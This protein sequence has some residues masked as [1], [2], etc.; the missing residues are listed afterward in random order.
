MYHPQSGQCVQLTKNDIVLANCKTASRW[1]QHQDG[2]PIK[3]A[4]SPQCLAVAGDGAAARASNDCSNKW[5]SVS[6]SGLHIAALEGKG[7]YLCLEK[8]TSDSKL[9]TKKCL[10]VGDNLAD[11][12]T[13]ADNPQV[14]WFKFV[15]ANV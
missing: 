14:Q 6:S 8:N 15:P 11:L 13:C 12:P 7:K 5:K 1:D 2:G 9:V 4:G 3:L 10:C